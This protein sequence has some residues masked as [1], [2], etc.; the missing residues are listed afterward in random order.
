MDI[1]VVGATLDKLINVYFQVVLNIMMPYTTDN[2]IEN[3]EGR[4]SFRGSEK[5][6]EE[7]TF[8]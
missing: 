6:T 5:V 4:A 2:G 3:E 7:V 1:A 8:T